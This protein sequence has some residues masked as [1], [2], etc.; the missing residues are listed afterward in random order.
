MHRHRESKL[1]NK[2]NYNA[3]SEIV[4]IKGRPKLKDLVQ[5]E[6]WENRGEMEQEYMRISEGIGFRKRD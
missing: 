4:S 6:R 5:R 2:R 1:Q 3:K